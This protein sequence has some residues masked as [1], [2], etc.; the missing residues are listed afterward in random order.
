MPLGLAEFAVEQLA[1]EVRFPEAFLL[2]DRAGNLAQQAKAFKG[3]LVSAEPG[4]VVFR[5][6]RLEAAFELTQARVIQHH[7][8]GAL[9]RFA[10]DADQLVALVSTI[11]EVASFTRIGF[12]A[13]AFR[14]TESLAAA[15]NKLLGT[16]LIRVPVGRSFDAEPTAGASFAEYGVRLQSRA[17][18]TTI[19]LRSDERRLEIE[20]PAGLKAFDSK[21]EETFGLI[22][23]VDQFTL[24][25]M[26]P[27]QLLTREWVKGA[28]HL[29]RRDVANFLAGIPG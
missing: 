16:G 26:E 8:E 27:A 20:A 14:K 21:V 4:K 7:P 9:E 22:L 6:G 25:P 23:D 29:Y 5:K 1:F 19:R 15:A 12:R 18:A 13:V 10:D 28:L 3:K 11:L 17:R 24:A 2:W